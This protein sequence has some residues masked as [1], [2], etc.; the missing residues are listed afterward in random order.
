MERKKKEALLFNRYGISVWGVNKFWRWMN[1]FN[2]TELYTSK[3]LKRQILCYIYFL[4]QKVHNFSFLIL[5]VKRGVT[6][7]RW[8]EMHTPETISQ[9]LFLW[10]ENSRWAALEWCADANHVVKREQDQVLGNWNFSCN[11]ATPSCDLSEESLT[12]LGLV[13]LSVKCRS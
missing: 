2:A 6:I 7:S 11:P 12:F 4:S 5:Y 3:W 10:S 8:V 1:V 9:F 13:L